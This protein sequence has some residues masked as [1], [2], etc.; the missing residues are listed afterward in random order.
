M[1]L[2]CPL[3]RYVAAATGTRLPQARLCLAFLAIFALVG[4]MAQTVAQAVSPAGQIEAGLHGVSMR[5]AEPQALVSAVG[6]AVAANPSNVAAILSEALSVGRSENLMLAGRLTGAAIGALGVEPPKNTVAL[7]VRMAVQMRPKAVLFVVTEA[8]AATPKPLA[9]V[10]V[11]AAVAA[12]KK[13][14]KEMAEQ[15]VKAALRAKRRS[16]VA[17]ADGK[18]VVDS[19]DA[20]E[21]AHPEDGVVPDQMLGGPNEDVEALDPEFAGLVRA[22]ASEGMQDNGQGGSGGQ[23]RADSGRGGTGG[24]G[25]DPVSRAFEKN[26]P[27]SIP[28]I[29]PSQGE[30][31]QGGNTPPVT[32]PFSPSR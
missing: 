31:G 5:N 13:P 4:L 12:L 22:A 25:N 20:K 11:R 15:I 21:V 3:W 26:G 29:P 19:K 18:D 17:R 10:I 30:S 1:I 8:V 7:C 16:V 2:N 14:S 27:G 23:T 32:V 9:P 24:D 6:A 28:P